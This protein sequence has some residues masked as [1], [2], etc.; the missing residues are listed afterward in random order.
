MNKRLSAAL[1]NGCLFLAPF[2][3]LEGV[4]RLLP[5]GEMPA[6]Q[7]VSAENPVVRYE[8]NVDYRYSRDWNFSIVTHR[9]S[10]NFGFIHA[11]DY[12]PHETGP[13]MAIIGT[14]FVEANVVDAGNGVAELLDSEVAGTGRVYGMG[15]SG[16]PLSQYLVFADYAKRT[17]RPQAMTFVI[18]NNL[19]QSFLKY[20]AEPRFHFFNEDGS[21][22]LVDYHLTPARSL[23][24][25]SAA[26]RYVM[27]N[28]DAPHRIKFFLNSLR[29]DPFASEAA[30]LEQHV[31]DS[32][33]AVDYF[34]DQL[35][36]ASGLAPQS[37]LLVLDAVRPAMY[38]PAELAK[39]D[40]GLHARIRRYI[41]AE[42]AARGYQVIDLQPV[43][44]ARYRHDGTKVEAAPTDSHWNAVGHRIVADE[45]R[46]SAVFARTFDRPGVSVLRVAAP[47]ER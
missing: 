13:L 42:A 1:V 31:K 32:K 34:F 39:V 2:L 21:L 47:L 33:R 11:T 44:L 5:V 23:L 15:V 27:Y 46:K 41:T 26:M 14:S 40:N 12:R 18:N 17:F 30:A 3:L 38:S 10:N 20:G 25:H 37:I 35:P 4:F 7:T 24:R 45:I 6:L 28:L 43:F 9:H 22:Q 19:H 29:Q 36:A 16:T 8:P